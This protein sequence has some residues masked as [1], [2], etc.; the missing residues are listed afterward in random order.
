MEN[1]ENLAPLAL[2]NVHV[3]NLKRFI[4]AFEWQQKLA[5]N[6]IEKVSQYLINEGLR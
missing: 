4:N 3:K 2:D 6:D 5:N 1:L